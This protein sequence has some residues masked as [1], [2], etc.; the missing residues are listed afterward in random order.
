MYSALMY[1]PLTFQSVILLV[2]FN[3]ILFVS[4]RVLH[5]FLSLVKFN[6]V[7]FLL[8]RKTVNA[9]FELHNLLQAE[10]ITLK[11]YIRNATVYYLQYKIKLET[12]DDNF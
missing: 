1:T 2:T 10:K 8:H 5:Y 11:M 12:S 3:F 9:K 7:C 4:V 6:L